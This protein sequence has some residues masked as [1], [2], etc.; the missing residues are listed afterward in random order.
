MY[1]KSVMETEA[2]AACHG[3]APRQ[4]AVAS[5]NM[6]LHFIFPTQTGTMANAARKILVTCALPYAN[7]SIHL[8]H[9]LEHIQAD[10]W[11]RYQR[12]RGN[13]IHFICADDAHGT[14]IMLKA[15]QLG[16]TPEQM[17]A[18]VSTEHQADF[19]GFGISFDNY[20][21][22]HSDENRELASLIY[23]RLRDG[24]YIKSRGISQLFDP[25]KSMFLPDRFVKGTCPKCKAVDQYGDNCDVCGATYSPTELIN[26]KSAVSGATPVMKETEHFFFDLPQFADM[27]Q[28]W[29]TSG[30]LQEEMANKLKE[31]FESGLQQWD[32]TRD[33]PY[34]GFEIPDAPGKYF[35][36]WL[37]AP[38][39]YM[40]SFKN[41]CAKRPEL[42]FDAF[43]SKESDA[44]L[45][46][47]IG[48]DIL[49][50][51]TLFWPA[52]L[53][54]AGF[55]KP[56]NVFVHGYVTVNG[57]KMSKSKGT[58]IKAGTYLQH[59]DPEYLRYYY[60]AKLNSR[61]D[62]LD[63]NL[64]DFVARVNADVVNKLV[65]LAS[66]TAG[67]ISKRFDGQLAATNT[68]PTLYSEFV[69]A[70]ERIAEAYE[71][72]EFS[73]AI[74]DIMAL[75]DIANRYVDEK[76]PWVIAKQE[77]REVELQEV[78]T[79]SLNLFRVLMTYLQ[80]VLPQLAERSAAFLQTSLSW[81]GI[82]A[83]LLAHS[84]AP[85]KALFS[86]IDPKKIEE[87]VSASKEDLVAEASKTQ[88][89]K[90]QHQSAPGKDTTEIEPIAPEIAYDDFA[91]L[92][93]RIAR[94]VNAELVADADKLLKLQLDIGGETRQVFAG[95]R[96][97]YDPATL[98][99]KLT[100]MV[101]NLAPRKMR[102]GMSEG[103]VLAAG[104][105]GKELYIL[106]PHDGAQ[107]GMRVK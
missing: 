54:G 61:I 14:P 17:I 31:W 69:A 22:T 4:I 75:A 3:I 101:A 8:G 102:F 86:R 96:S 26:P 106:E 60:A 95:I 71:A 30:A 1:K 85:F 64:D 77:G 47:F 20:H 40:G 81:D 10:I 66:R 6:L 39:G 55:R 76:A 11:V 27:L 35:Y 25:E 68:E 49:Y 90:S 80:P 94:I 45:Y 62:D 50:F 92:D 24:G 53:E 48:K 37:D 19:A 38:I 43:W 12:L 9:M 5:G 21:S 72:R 99:G 16:I 36:V 83:P 78:C 103:M 46:H 89:S 32:I 98:V 59:L 28:N 34:F 67:F 2:I 104:P 33:A 44:E 100:V 41:L 29:T 74:R 105:G 56:S 82:D 93:L 58:F 18:E 87:M 97:A 7:G 91:K 84:I 70:R 42:D 65:N 23:T 15:Q 63:L 73:R 88:G 13:T 51:H 52:M 57:A 79:V 107:P